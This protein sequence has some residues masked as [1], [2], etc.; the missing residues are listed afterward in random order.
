MTPFALYRYDHNSDKYS[1]L[2]ICTKNN[3]HVTYQEYFPTLN[4][5]KFM[6]SSDNHRV[7][8]NISFLLVYRKNNSNIL[9]FINGI[10]YLLRSNPIDIILGD[11]NIN[12]FNSKDME[13]LTSLMESL[14]Y[15][16][17]V[18]MPTFISGSLLDHVYV[19][20]AN[21]GNIDSSV[22]SVYYSDHDAI[23]ITVRI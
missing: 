23:K 11:F 15:L 20:Q 21:K 13:P 7:Q 22:I 2:A 16:Q 19:R 10:D 8:A 9:G 17:I 14:D 5:V 18:K 12:Y 1:S 4:A 3:I 6:F